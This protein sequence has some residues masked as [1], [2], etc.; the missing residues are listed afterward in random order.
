MSLGRTV[1]L[2]LKRF[3]RAYEDSTFG[4]YVLFPLAISVPTYILTVGRYSSQVEAILVDTSWPLILA[5]MPTIGLIVARL[6]AEYLRN[7]APLPSREY[8]L[9]LTCIEDFVSSKNEKFQRAA[10]TIN[11][12]SDHAEV[13]GLITQP[14]SRIKKIVLAVKLFFG[15]IDKSEY[16]EITVSLAKMGD[17][18]VDSFLCFYPYGNRPAVP[19]AKYH[20]KC[21]GFSRAK[22]WNKTVVICDIQEE[23]KKIVVER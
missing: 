1:W 20:H 4:R 6:A 2:K 12:K 18:Y 10:K 11:N 8:S 16:N 13:F 7:E 15:L 3:Y 17:S 5:G 14:Y 22:E 23:A 9:L 19:I 21:C